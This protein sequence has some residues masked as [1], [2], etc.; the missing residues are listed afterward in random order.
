[1]DERQSFI[2]EFRSV[3]RRRGTSPEDLFA[4]YDRDE[5]GLIR[6]NFLTKI[7][8]SVGFYFDTRR[9]NQVTQGFIEG[10]MFNYRKFLSIPDP[11]VT[12]REIISDADLAEFGRFLKSRR[13]E[14]IDTLEQ[15]DFHHSGHVS[16]M[17]FLRSF[18]NTPLVNK[19]CNYFK[20]P[21]NDVDYIGLNNEMKR[22]LVQFDGK[23]TTPEPV[24]DQLPPFFNKIA[25]DIKTQRI[26]LKSMFV[27]LDRFKKGFL[28]K[29]DFRKAINS[30]NLRVNANQLY[31]VIDM[32][33]DERGQV[34]YQK[35]CDEVENAIKDIPNTTKSTF[36]TQGD[37]NATLSYIKDLVRN[38]HFPL[39]EQIKSCDPSNSGVIPS[40]NFFRALANGPCKLGNQDVSVLE[41]EFGDKN[42]NI[43]YQRFLQ[44]VS[45]QQRIAVDSPERTLVRLKQYLETK[46]IQLRPKLQR[47]EH[48]GSISMA[49][50]LQVLRSISF[51]MTQRESQQLSALLAPRLNSRIDINSFCEQVD[52]MSIPQR[53]TLQEIEAEEAE[54]AKR[55]AAQRE[56]RPRPPEELEETLVIVLQYAEKNS[57]DFGTEFRQRD[58]HRNGAIPKSQFQSVL[59]M[60]APGLST[61]DVNHISE[62]YMGSP[63]QINYHAFLQD[64]HQHI[65]PLYES[66]QEEL[67][68]PKE[69]HPETFQ[70]IRRFKNVLNDQRTAPEDVFIRYDNLRSGT[71]PKTRLA[72]IFETLGFRISPVEERCLQ[73]DFTDARLPEMFN[74]R[75]FCQQLNQTTLTPQDLSQIRVHP[76]NVNVQD[77]EVAVLINSIR[78]RIQERHK[79]VR[80]AFSEY[81]KGTGIPANEFRRAFST[82]GLFI[83][84]N[85]M[86]KLLKY[87]RFSRQGDVDWDSFCHDVETSKTVQ[88]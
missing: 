25:Y 14:L 4:E 22:V 7:L 27:Q 53:K 71:V 69:P 54:E 82:F 83:K 70:V 13:I 42:G 87:Y 43:E 52:P 12:R 51:D 60:A 16:P 5:S 80:E 76:E 81:E 47:Y 61:K 79:R 68:K 59:M 33:T 29:D 40:Q 15:F 20:T 34:P 35:F 72:A 11:E 2:S 77:R 24:Y 1:M 78:E 49:E 18:G 23:S 75:R 73:E 45:P 67:N 39:E 58:V 86:L 48:Q 28:S 85:D 88:F 9:L 44:A 63:Q 36:S 66:L 21:T 31:Q 3:A 65:R 62:Y 57:V 50:L 26:D 38:R 37:I 6:V 56:V 8:G 32:F 10:Q 19:I 46:K 64:I 55:Q 30:L 74:Y 84:E 41:Q 17:N